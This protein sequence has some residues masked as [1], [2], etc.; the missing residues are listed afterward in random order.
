MMRVSISPSTSS[1]HTTSLGL[2]RFLSRAFDG[3]LDLL[4]VRKVVLSD[5]HAL[6]FGL[7][8][9]LQIDMLEQD[10]IGMLVVQK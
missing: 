5:V 2:Q 10:E 8:D 4:Q 6:Q 7:V 3:F 9:A 1:G